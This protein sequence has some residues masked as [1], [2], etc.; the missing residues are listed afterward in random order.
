MGLSGGKGEMIDCAP[1]TNLFYN[2]TILPVIRQRL[3]PGEHIIITGVFGDRSG[4]AAE[5]AGE[6]PEVTADGGQI[7]VTW[8]GK[9]VK[10]NF[11]IENQ[12]KM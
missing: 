9:T 5:R 7:L 1:N 10:T 6:I 12:K 2:L 3:E 4:K 11:S 8:G